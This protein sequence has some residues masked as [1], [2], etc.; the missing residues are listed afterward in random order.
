MKAKFRGKSTGG[1]TA[2]TAR[3]LIKQIA[4]DS[5]RVFIVPHA[6]KRMDERCITRTQILRCLLHGR[7]VEGPAQQIRGNWRFT[8]E[9]CCAGEGINVVAEIEEDINGNTIIVVTVM[10]I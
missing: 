6:Q 10:P 1:I 7:I 8:V 5:S 9:T 4:S 2:E 3:K